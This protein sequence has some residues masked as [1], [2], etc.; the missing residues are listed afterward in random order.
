MLW[1]PPTGTAAAARSAPCPGCDSLDDR[2]HSSCHPPGSHASSPSTWPIPTPL[3]L[4][5]L[6]G[7]PWASMHTTSP[8]L[9]YS[10]SAGPS[11]SRSP[12]CSQRP[13]PLPYQIV[14]FF[15]SVVPSACSLLRLSVARFRGDLASFLPGTCTANPVG[16][17]SSAQAELKGKNLYGHPRACLIWETTAFRTST[18]ACPPVKR[19]F[20]LPHAVTLACPY[21][22]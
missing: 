13:A 17:E 1:P 11:T 8:W 19:P 18:C 21:H 7:W 2:R 5:L 14:S 15:A 10:L 3:P 16:M 12:L 22:L 4:F 20:A 6:L 9:P